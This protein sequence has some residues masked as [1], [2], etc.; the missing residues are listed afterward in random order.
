[1]LLFIQPETHFLNHITNHIPP[2]VVQALVVHQK[3]KLPKPKANRNN[4]EA[5]IP[6][7][8]HLGRLLPPEKTV[9]RRARPRTKFP[10]KNK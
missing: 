7:V 5:V 1:M 10:T 6:L 2:L 8:M 9:G 3:P 4:T